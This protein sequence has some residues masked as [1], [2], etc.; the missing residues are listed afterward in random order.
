MPAALS[1]CERNCTRLLIPRRH[2]E[3]QIA[4]IFGGGD[5]TYFLSGCVRERAPRS[6][7]ERAPFLFAHLSEPRAEI[8]AG[9]PFK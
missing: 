2:C 9:R 6:R 8:T 7:L 5:S 1:N 3:C 4:F